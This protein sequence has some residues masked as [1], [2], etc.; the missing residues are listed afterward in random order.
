[1]KI[2]LFIHSNDSIKKLDYFRQFLE[3]CPLLGSLS[4]IF[5]YSNDEDTFPDILKYF[6]RFPQKI[7]QLYIAS[8]PVIETETTQCTSSPPTNTKKINK[9][10]RP[11]YALMDCIEKGMFEQ[12]DYVILIRSGV[13]IVRETEIMKV[14]EENLENNN[15]YLVTKTILSDPR[16]IRD[17]FIIA[18]PKQIF[19]NMLDIHPF[20]PELHEYN[21]YNDFEK[22]GV[23]YA[24]ID[25]F[26]NDNMFP[27][28]IADCLGI[29]NDPDFTKVKQYL[30]EK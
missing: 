13:Y 1:M 28:H 25:R 3:K 11:I 17:D 21:I 27:Y 22:N 20:Q 8:N 9:Y 10:Y 30:N 7:K 4:D 2:L 18:K 16:Y 6:N 29:W 24:V 14:L 23:K 5:V 12:Y 19:G 26:E 15:S